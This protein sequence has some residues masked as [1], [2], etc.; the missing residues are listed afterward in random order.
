MKRRSGNCYQDAFNNL[1]AFKEAHRYMGHWVLCHGVATL[2]AGPN[3]GKEFGHAWIETNGVV[4]DKGRPLVK[5]VYYAIG[6]IRD[7]RR[8]EIKEALAFSLE[9]KHFGPWDNPAIDKA[10]EWIKD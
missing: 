6:K 5:D 7:V 4:I 3:A 9:E 2:A 8:F 1:L 10:E